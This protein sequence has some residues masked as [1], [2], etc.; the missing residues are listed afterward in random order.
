MNSSI[1]AFIE[2]CQWD[3]AKFFVFSDNVF[4]PLIY[5][6][7]FFALILS[8]TIGTFILLKDRKSLLNKLL[9]LITFMFS[10]WAIF[11]L[12]LWA[13]EKPEY[14]MFFW[15]SVVL[16][17][18][19]IYALC[20]YF[21]DIFF[22]K[23]DIS[24]KKKLGIF[25]PLLPIIILLP[26]KFVLQDF[27]LTNCY[28][29]ITEGFVAVYYV[30]MV[31]IIYVFW[32][33]LF[34]FSKSSTASK[35][36]KRQIFLITSGIILFL[37]SLASGNIIGSLT[38]N[39]TLAQIG[40]FGMPIFIAFLAY[41]IVKFKTF[42]IKLIGTQALV[43]AL[44]FLVL[45]ILFIRKIE[46]VRVVV[47]FTLL[48]VIALGYALIKSVKKEVRQKEE[49]AV[50]NEQLS[51]FMSF[52]SHEIKGPMGFIK[53][54][55]AM[56]LEGNMGELNPKLKEVMR[57]IY[58]RSNDLIDL[59]AQYL[60]KS[61][62]ELNQISY[63]FE[64]FDIGAELKQV[65]E[66]FQQNAEEQKIIVKYD[67]AGKEI[68]PVKADKGKMKEVFRNI[69]GNA[70]K[71][72]PKGSVEVFISKTNN[73]VLVK[74]KDTGNGIEK[75]KIPALF[76]KFSRADTQVTNSGG[77][78]LGLYLAKVFVEAHHGKIWIESEGIGKGATFFV[79]LPAKQ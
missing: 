49:L 25:L 31:E 50:I 48:F 64:D 18:P 78:G 69:I 38:E 37:L 8:I 16:I 40:L 56:A 73:S 76:K 7:H 43:F 24:F 77:S 21:I 55:V 58:I 26:T 5:Y 53:G 39:W 62:I 44:G 45:A 27:D 32:I 41:M 74:V 70:I 63:A 60:N 71:F 42:N 66:D 20:L 1:Q 68:F 75:E 52:A 51:E 14:S 2:I 29:D 23:K 46:N 59:A 10:V 34:A 33:L 13:T 9:F 36:E 67:S 35:E 17:E 61:K 54:I 6:S 79:E 72:T 12:I 3:T 11:D 57:R 28:R 4:G 22:N 47:I 19:L 15:S 65:V 30:Y